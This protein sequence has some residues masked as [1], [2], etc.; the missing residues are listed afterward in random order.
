MP[1]NDKPGTAQVSSLP[2][3]TQSK[4]IPPQIK[5]QL[6]ASFGG[7]FSKVRLHTGQEATQ[8][9]IGLGARAF[10][11]G[12]DIFYR[13]A[14]DTEAKRLLAHELTHVVQQRQGAEQSGDGSVRK[15]TVF[16]AK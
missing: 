5:A 16:K 3:N 10:A 11:H 2:K 6:Q 7:D 4:E 13:D 1:E 8:A 15:V 14:L 12:Q 9:C